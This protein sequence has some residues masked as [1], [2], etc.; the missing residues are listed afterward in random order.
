MTS[1]DDTGERRLN[2]GSMAATQIRK[3]PGLGYRL[4]SRLTSPT[5]NKQH[6]AFLFDTVIAGLLDGQALRK[7]GRGTARVAAELRR[8]CDLAM[9]DIPAGIQN[10]LE[11]RQGTPHQLTL[12]LN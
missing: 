12:R 4:T 10:F 3:H 7:V 9:R 1:P 5:T 6:E 2:L 11:L 8:R